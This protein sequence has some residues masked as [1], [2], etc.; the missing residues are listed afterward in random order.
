MNMPSI[1]KRT[2]AVKGMHCAACSSR[3]ERVVGKMEGVQRAAVNLAA[4]SVELVWDSDVLSF[5]AIAGRVK[6][7]G[8][9]LERE[10]VG[11]E[12]IMEL[13]ISGMH[14][15]ACSARIEKVVSAM[16]GVV[17]VRVNLLTGT[18][19][20]TYRKGLVSQ[21]R[22]R[23]EIAGLGFES[24]PVSAG[25]DQFARRRQEDIDRLALM[26]KRLVRLLGLAALLLFLSMGEMLGLP[27][28]VG[29]NPHL[30]P[31]RFALLQFVL[32]APIMVLG[33]SFYLVGIPALLRRVPNMD[34]LIAMGTGAAFVYSTW[35]M[36]EIMLE[37]DAHRQAMLAMDLYFESAGVLIAL[38]SLGK[39]LETRS[40]SHT[41][42]A[43][44]GLMRLT[45]DRAILLKGEE[46][47]EIL[48]EEIE[49]GDLIL[50]RPGE[51]VPVD[52]V[53]VGGHTAVDESML[54][55]ESLPVSKAEGDR[56]TC[57]T[58]NKSGAVRVRTGQVGQDT[59]LARIVRTVQ[60]A[61]GSKAPIAGLADRISLY[62]V[63]AVMAVAVLA[64]LAW[65]TVGGADFTTALR[66]FIAVMVIACPCAMGLAT[67]T[68][69]MVGTGRGAQLGVLMKSGEALEM[70]E[71]VKV[72]VFDKTGTLTYGRP[73]LTDLVNVNG[74][75]SDDRMLLLA[76]SL[77]QSSEH[78]LAEA[79]VAAARAKGF[80][81]R[82]PEDFAVMAGRGVSGRVDGQDILLGNRQHLEESGIVVE[83]ANQEIVGFSGQGKTVLFLAVDGHFA[84]LIAIAD[85]LKAEVP[86]AISRLRRM[87]LRLIMLTGDQEITARAIAA[88]AGIDEVIAQVMPERKADAI[89]E[90]R[91]QG[92]VT[93]M[94][95]DGI[96][97]APALAVAD[98]GIAMGT[99]TDIAIESGDIVL[100]QGNLEGVVVALRLSRAVMRNIRQNLFWAFAYNVVGIPVA[101]GLLVLFGGP[102]LSPMIAGAAM[103]MSSVS[104]VGNALRLRRFAGGG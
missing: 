53:I 63:P 55:G 5:E 89:R 96:N 94:V 29:L 82:Q 24:R 23:E 65:Y 64:G 85:R 28:P 51:R 11:E 66:Y 2:V 3:I 78:P 83:G 70:A 45:P 17:S 31:L 40:K 1:Q 16:D 21:R 20:V 95:G 52:G 8:F 49:V 79:L 42:D 76:A 62:F 4:E 98:V 47:V 84:G 75:Q 33:R 30:H 12:L 56:V 59:M 43:I 74:G 37:V 54:T 6:E 10:G 13:A 88:Q 14:C 91:Q 26:K 60:E 92:L 93:A 48:V 90:L 18:G 68:S 9:E 103:A 58:L 80:E 35:N 34:S 97:D 38:V 46:Q 44:A 71:K 104:V 39:Y 101:A 100:M 86:A 36:A 77:E 7:L 87:G 15:A 69:I 22:I 67:P 19:T 73:E 50:V 32:V 81:L 25:L 27:L 41:S 102:S 99:G 72:L 61:Q 57:G